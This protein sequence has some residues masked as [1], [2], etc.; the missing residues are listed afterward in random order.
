MRGTLVNHLPFPLRD[1]R[2]LHAGWLYDIG[3]FEPGE[4][5]DTEAGR[6]PRSLA[7]ALTRR[8]AVGD[9]DRTERWDTASLDVARILEVA[10]FHAAA[11]GLGYT[12]VE[13]G[14]LRRL[15]LSPLLAVDRAIVVGRAPPG[16]RGTSGEIRLHRDGLESVALAPQAADQGTLVRIV[17]PLFAAEEEPE[18]LGMS[19][20]P[21][22]PDATTPA[23][24][25]P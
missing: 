3:D 10:G 15:D 12:A 9:R 11:G 19:A 1:C 13:P 18:T 21:R 4:T 23:E 20:P 6:G 14:R 16:V 17:V 5:F 7:A 24:E 22:V 25:K 8:V 2:L